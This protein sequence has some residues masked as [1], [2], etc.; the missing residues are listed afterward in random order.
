MDGVILLKFYAGLV[1]QI[2]NQTM[3]FTKTEQLRKN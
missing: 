2:Y 3:I 1:H